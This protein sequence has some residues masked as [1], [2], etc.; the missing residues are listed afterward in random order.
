MSRSLLLLAL[1][2]A[3]AL[4]AL[5]A[6]FAADW[7]VLVSGSNTYSNYRHTADVCHAYQILKK[8]G[9]KEE[10]IITMIYDDIANHRSNPFP[11]KVYNFPTPAGTEGVDVYEGV[12]IDYTGNLVN[13]GVFLAVITGNSTGVPPG[14]PVLKSG[15][16]DRIFINF[17]D[18]GA[19]GLIAFPSQYLYANDLISAF[20]KMYEAKMYKQM[21]F[22]LETCESGSMFEGLLDPSWNIYA[23]TAANAHES[24]WGTYCPPNDKVNGKSVGSC[25]GDLYSVNWMEHTDQVGTGVSLQKQFELVRDLTT[26]S[27]VM[28]Y[29]D[30][31]YTDQPIGDFMGNGKKAKTPKIVLQS[32]KAEAHLDTPLRPVRGSSD[33]HVSSRDVKMHEIYYRYLRAE[34]FTTESRE[35]LA[36]LRAELDSREAAEK[37]FQSMA[38]LLSQDANG[39]LIS[40]PESLFASPQRPVRIGKCVQTAVDTMVARGCDYDDFS[41]QFHNVIVNSCA[42]YSTE[43]A[44]VEA[45]LKAV[46][47]VC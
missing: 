9:F 39:K 14:K 6:A 21:V 42:R 7:A 2:A 3:V 41:L 19:P 27:H 1:V 8:N 31:S 17:V 43:E 25:L 20:K 5:P 10:N 44:G 45:V 37:R 38:T 47:A 23:T 29:G 12:K 4:A 15:K 46:K 30:L 24:S 28:Q 16:E 33:S 34:R 11:G 35:A 26:R 36:E 32:E 18:H 22:Y 40:N 13:P